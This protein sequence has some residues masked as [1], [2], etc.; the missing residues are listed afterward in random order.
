MI[1]IL[2]DTGEPLATARLQGGREGMTLRIDHLVRGK[3]RLFKYYFSEGRRD[4]VVEWGCFRLNGGLATKWGG[5]CRLW[6]VRLT[7]PRR[8]G[9]P[10]TGGIQFQERPENRGRRW[11]RPE[12]GTDQAGN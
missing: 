9:Q 8:I 12:D 7:D 11:R 5:N 10:R 2:S 1:R 4:V 6:Q 3:G